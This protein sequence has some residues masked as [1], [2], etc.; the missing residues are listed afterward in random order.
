L[1]QE[2]RTEKLDSS[3]LG[4]PKLSARAMVRAQIQKACKGDT[5]AFSAIADRS[6]GKPSVIVSGDHENPLLVSVARAD[7]ARG[8]IEDALNRLAARQVAIEVV[9]SDEP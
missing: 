5:L 6:D 3:L 8:R 9:A 4:M 2:V 1:T 7:D